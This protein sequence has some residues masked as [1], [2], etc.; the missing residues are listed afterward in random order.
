MKTAAWI[1]TAAVVFIVAVGLGAWWVKGHA[2]SCDD[3]EAAQVLHSLPGAAGSD[4]DRNISGDC[5][6]EYET[7]EPLEAFFPALAATLERE[8][9]RVTSETEIPTNTVS[10][11]RGGWQIY[12]EYL[13]DGPPPGGVVL[14]DA[15]VFE[16]ED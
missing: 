16:L 14:V 13:G 15:S 7:S 9:W 8:G 3:A 2:S 12:V 5:H 1:L 6:L 4:V 10:A 11:R